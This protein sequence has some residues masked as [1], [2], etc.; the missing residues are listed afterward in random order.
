MIATSRRKFL[1]SA[2]GLLA[3]ACAPSEPA[4]LR[5]AGTVLRTP[6]EQESALASEPTKA[7]VGSEHA[8]P[9][10]RGVPTPEADAHAA[11]PT[12]TP[13]PTPAPEPI[14]ASDALPIPPG[15]AG[16][17]A[18]AHVLP[19]P[20]KLPSVQALPAKRVII[21]TIGL[22]SKVIQ[23]GTRL[24]KRGLLAWETAPFAIGHHRGTAGPGQN[25]NMV[26]S[27]H[28]SSPNE[29]AVFHRLPDL[30]VGEGVIVATDE[31]QYLYRVVD[32]KV[33]TPDEVSVMEPTPD[34]SATLIT[35]VPD[36]IYSHRLVVT[37]KLV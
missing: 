21:P 19:V 5:G 16:T 33:V 31:R 6:A 7:A 12:P 32:R 25:G 37:A 8:E 20:Q 3:V 27:G 9:E 1:V 11:L 23:L 26:L 28:I 17:E 24:D 14:V 30:K 15:L 4:G 29:G 22:D 2:L 35:C 10:L 34:P 13:L 36:G 18:E